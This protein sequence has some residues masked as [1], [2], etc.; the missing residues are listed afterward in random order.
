MLQSK[1]IVLKITLYILIEL[2]KGVKEQMIFLDIDTEKL[3]DE[4]YKDLN[5]NKV[6]NIKAEQKIEL[7]VR[8][9]LDKRL[10]AK[11]LKLYSYVMNFSHLGYTQEEISDMLDMSRS[12]VN[13]S[14]EKLSAFNYV[15]KVKG[16]SRRGERVSYVLVDLETAGICSIG[17]QDIM[18]MCNVGKISKNE[19]FKCF[20]DE[21]TVR[22]MRKCKKIAQNDIK[23][24]KEIAQY[25][26]V[27]KYFYEK[28]IG[29]LGSFS[30]EMLRD[31]IEKGK[32]YLIGNDEIAITNN[33]FN[34]ELKILNERIESIDKDLEDT[35]KIEKDI[36]NFKKDFYK[37]TKILNKNKVNELFEDK[38]IFLLLF[39][40][41]SQDE[42]IIRFKEQYFDKYVKFL[43][44]FANLSESYDF[45]KLLYEKAGEQ[46]FTYDE[47]L[48]LFDIKHRDTPGSKLE[49]RTTVEF[50]VED[51]I[52][53]IDYILEKRESTYNEAVGV[54][55]IKD[56][57]Y[58]IEDLDKKV[59]GKI[60]DCETMLSVLALTNR[61]NRFMQCYNIDLLD[62]ANIIN[63]SYADNIERIYAVKSCYYRLKEEEKQLKRL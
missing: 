51:L 17:P 1:N 16:N 40:N 11:D 7:L 45:F 31:L 63:K 37:T 49:G 35:N 13:K 38:N 14:F 15:V 25:K 62:Y 43:V 53:K 59:N 50:Y 58:Y 27:K 41:E 3:N 29:E 54:I 56:V 18:R 6:Q 22:K 61:K 33:F 34:Y 4:L 32:E 46:G 55:R 21:D 60:I 23:I 47:L 10:N 42:R 28:S 26:K 48:K 2:K 8:A 44:R 5:D 9:T 30:I 19:K 57:R 12:N 24:L 39:I 52:E 20:E 36:E